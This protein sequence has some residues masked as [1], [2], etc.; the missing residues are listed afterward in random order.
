MFVVEFLRL[1]GQMSII[2]NRIN[3]MNNLSVEE[4]ASNNELI[5]IRQR[6]I[7]LAHMPN[8]N[9]RN[10]IIDISISLNIQN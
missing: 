3:V 10:Q 6:I 4:I 1:L 9:E 5:P 8:E 2:I 7:E